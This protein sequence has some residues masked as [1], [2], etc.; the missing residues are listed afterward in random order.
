MRY[1]SKII[2]F[3][4]CASYVAGDFVHDNRESDETKAIQNLNQIENLYFKYLNKRERQEA[5]FL[6][7]QTRRL[8]ING[9]H[10]SI[11]HATLLDSKAYN[12]MLENVKIASSDIER[13]KIIQSIGGNRKIS[14]EQLE[15]FITCYTFNSYKEDI[16]KK[17]ADKIID[18]INIGV[19][20]RHIESSI[21][22]DNLYDYF[23]D[24]M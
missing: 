3:I 23:K 15:S 1:Y 4:L 13:N 19:V 9:P 22:R 16:V 12:I 10:Q 24:R 2:L 14:C 11:P 5:I 6:L 20:I 21:T 18:P 17:M 7:N 8:I